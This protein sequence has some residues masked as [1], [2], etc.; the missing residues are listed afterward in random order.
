MNDF[1]T[2]LI[3]LETIEKNIKQA[4]LSEHDISMLENEINFLKIVILEKKVKTSLNK[5]KG[6]L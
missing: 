3:D 1:E 5:E 4:T 6:L 2:I